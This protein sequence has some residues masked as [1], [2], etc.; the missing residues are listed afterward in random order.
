MKHRGRE[1]VDGNSNMQRLAYERYRREVL[2]LD[3]AD[4]IGVSRQA[5][6]RYEVEKN[7]APFWIVEAMCNAL[8]LKL[9]IFDKKGNKFYESKNV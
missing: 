4:K 6:G 3:L 9:I 2:I 8:G 5:L 1:R 7:D